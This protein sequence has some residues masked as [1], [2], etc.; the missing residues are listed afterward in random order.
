M[1]ISQN[2][3][4]LTY[5]EFVELIEYFVSMGGPDIDEVKM[6]SLY[7]R[8]STYD[9]KAV[10][11]ACKWW[12]YDNPDKW[13]NNLL[14]LLVRRTRELYHPPSK[15]VDETGET[16]CLVN[17][18]G[19][20]EHYLPLPEIIERDKLIEAKKAAMMLEN[21]KPVEPVTDWKQNL[22]QV[23]KGTEPLVSQEAKA[24][25]QVAKLKGMQ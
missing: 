7:R 1:K 25:E 11:L 6:K 15:F 21:R 12:I 24:A 10:A 17:T 23:V 8:V 5:P 2:R 4:K 14:H 22:P 20:V 13:E 9:G 19:G 16:M 18:I 3:I